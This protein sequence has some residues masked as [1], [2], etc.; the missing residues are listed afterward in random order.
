MT[1]HGRALSELQKTNSLLLFFGVSEAASVHYGQKVHQT[2]N[3][4]NKTRETFEVVGNLSGVLTGNCLCSDH[5]RKQTE[6][7]KSNLASKVRNEENARKQ[8]KAFRGTTIRTL[9]VSISFYCSSSYSLVIGLNLALGSR[10]PYS[11][12][13][14]ASAS[15]GAGNF[16]PS[17]TSDPS[18]NSAS[19]GKEAG[20]MEW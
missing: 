10:L 16:S 13:S 17:K 3:Q 9:R 14:A 15:R 1:Q 20:Y 5:S 18:G 11:P 6:R 19:T 2:L 7:R 4:Q 8:C 12:T